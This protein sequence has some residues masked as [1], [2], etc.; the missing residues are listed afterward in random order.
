MQSLTE[1]HHEDLG[2]VTALYTYEDFVKMSS[3]LSPSD[4]ADENRVGRVLRVATDEEKKLLPM[5]SER[6]GPLLKACQTFVDR[7]CLDMAVHGVEYQFDGNV[8]FVYYAA[9]GRV[10]FRSLVQHIVRIYCRKTRIQMK[11]TSQCRDFIPE[12]F[13]AEALATG[14]YFV[15]GCAF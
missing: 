2:V 10:D 12:R 14:Q 11:K 5:K 9:R 3:T 8:L 1:Q 15:P 4:D 7:F 13:A 6:E